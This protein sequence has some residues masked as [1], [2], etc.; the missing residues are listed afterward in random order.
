MIWTKMLTKYFKVHTIAIRFKVAKGTFLKL[1][2]ALLGTCKKPFPSLRQWLIFR[3]YYMWFKLWS[4]R[5]FKRTVSTWFAATWKIW[6]INEFNT[7]SFPIEHDNT[8]QIK[9]GKVPVEHDRGQFNL[10]TKLWTQISHRLMV[11]EDNVNILNAL[12]LLS[13]SQQKSSRE[14]KHL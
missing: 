1:L 6:G 7:D 12:K 8:H 9:I 13:Q 11:D 3:A 14:N 5:A 2:P 4:I 10:T